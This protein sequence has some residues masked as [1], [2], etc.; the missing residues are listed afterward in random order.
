MRVTATVMG[1]PSSFHLPEH[2]GTAATDPAAAR[3]AVDAAVDLLHEA[4]QRFSRHVATS[5]LRAVRRGDLDISRV[6][7]DM[8]DVLALADEA[9]D[10]SSGAFDVTGPDGLLDT[11]GVVKGWAVQRA[12]DLVACRGVVDLC[13]NVGGDVA[14]RGGPEPGRPWA[15]AVADPHDRT[16]TAAV[17]HVSDGG[18][19]TSGT[20]ERGTHVWDGR[21]G[22]PARGLASLTV[23]AETLT[24][25]DILATAG[26]ALGADGLGWVVRNGAAWALE[27]RPDGTQAQA[28]RPPRG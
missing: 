25:A 24:R 12:A 7:A 5:E 3:A 15:V 10:A 22:R 20:A 6:S 4:E 16:R 27:I 21:T 26:F 1:I 13:V 14:V 18:V 9:R 2:R 8:R 28:I 19:A 11:D 17:V 23:V